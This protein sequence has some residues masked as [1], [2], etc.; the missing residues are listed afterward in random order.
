MVSFGLSIVFGM[1]V[2][3]R[4]EDGIE[5]EL[6][7]K[8]HRRTFRISQTRLIKS[9]WLKQLVRQYRKK[10][11]LVMLLSTYVIQS[12]GCYKYRKWKGA[13]T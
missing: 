10:C 8:G 4:G 12:S 5:I 9:L 13:E 1:Y 6:L 2:K 3:R 7:V 11:I